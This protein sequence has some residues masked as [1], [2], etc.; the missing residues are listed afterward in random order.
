MYVIYRVFYTKCNLR[1]LLNYLLEVSLFR[2]NLPTNYL[3]YKK[4]NSLF[5]II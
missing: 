2:Y 3:S 4:C 1:M 5:N